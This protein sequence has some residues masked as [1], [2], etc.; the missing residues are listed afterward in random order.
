MPKKKGQSLIATAGIEK[1][2]AASEPSASIEAHSAD[3]NTHAV[4]V[5]SGNGDAPE[6]N[7]LLAIMEEGVLPQYHQPGH[8]A[9]TAENLKILKDLIQCVRQGC[10]QY[11]RHPTCQANGKSRALNTLIVLNEK[12]LSNNIYAQVRMILGVCIFFESP[13]F[14]AAVL[15]KIEEKF[16]VECEFNN[17]IKQFLNT[18]EE[19]APYRMYAK[20]FS[21]PE[22]QSV[23]SFAG[24]G[25]IEACSTTATTFV[26]FWQRKKNDYVFD[27]YKLKDLIAKFFNCCFN[28][29]SV[30]TEALTVLI[31]SLEDFRQ[32]RLEMTQDPSQEGSEM[33]RIL[34]RNGRSLP[35]LKEVIKT[36]M[37]TTPE[38]RHIYEAVISASLIGEE[39]SSHAC[40]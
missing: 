33:R 9:L 40:E 37:L 32:L 3:E 27:E 23:S 16:A 12:L 28:I 36:S 18:L 6:K 1:K 21:Q 24:G 14:R 8:R 19:Y 35:M 39:C 5:L 7:P 31:G 13:N 20:A 17:S 2:D 34:F 30:D 15:N 26:S 22:D 11:L 38:A 10:I 29:H 25:V 4:D